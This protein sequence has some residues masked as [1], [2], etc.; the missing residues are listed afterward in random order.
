MY[1]VQYKISIFFPD[2]ST[3]QIKYKKPGKDGDGVNMKKNVKKVSTNVED[4][5]ENVFQGKLLI[6]DS[7]YFSYSLLIFHTVYSYLLNHFFR[8]AAD[9]SCI[10]GHVVVVSYFLSLQIIS[11]L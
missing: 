6:Q 9:I 2:Y 8:S 7:R 5:R 1:F 4:K 3:Q 11:L 10:N